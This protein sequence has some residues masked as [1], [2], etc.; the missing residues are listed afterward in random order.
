MHLTDATIDRYGPLQNWQPPCREG[1]T[2]IS[3]PNEAGKTLYLEGLLRL[4]DP[5]VVDVLTSEPRVPEAP[6]GRVTVRTNGDHYTLAEERTL[7]EISAIEPAHLPSIFVVRDEDLALPGEADFYTSLIQKLGNIH[8]TEIESIKDRLRERGRLT[9]ANRNLSS[10]AEFDDAGDVRDRAANLADDIREY[11]EHVK[12][13]G[14]A[15]LE[16]ER[17]RC[18]QALEAALDS[19]ERLAATKRVAE[20]E[21]LSERLEKFREASEE[22]ETLAAFDRETL[23]ALRAHRQEITRAEGELETLVADIEDQRAE[24]QRLEDTLADRNRREMRLSRREEAIERVEQRLAAYRQAADVSG[25]TGRQFALVKQFATAGLIGAGIAGGAGAVSGTVAA[26]VLAGVLAVVGGLAGAAAFAI[27]RKRGRIDERRE[28]TLRAA[29]DAEL[30]CEAIEDVAPAVESFNNDLAVARKERT[31]ADSEL[32]TAREALAE[33]EAEQ[34]DCETE[35]EEGRVEL[36]ETLAAAGVK[37]I[38]DYESA[39][40]RTEDLETDRTS[41]AASLRDRFG[42]PDAESDDDRYTVWRRSL[43]DL[44][45][46]V[47][48]EAHDPT[49]DPETELAAVEEEVNEYE[50]ELEQLERDLAAYQN[51]LDTFERRVSDIEAGPF[52]DEPIRLAARTKAGL[53][54][55]AERLE[56]FVG[57]IDRDAEHSRKAL[58]LFDRIEAAEE[59]K[60]TTLFAPDGRA[61]ATFERIT[62]G[63]YSAI[64]YDADAH[65]LRVERADGREF[66]PDLLSQGTRDQLYFASR[67][68]LAEQLLGSEPGFFLLDDP[69]LAADPERLERGFETLLDLADAGWQIIY[70]T[71][72]PEVFEDM[73]AEY[74]LAHE[75][76]PGLSSL[77]QS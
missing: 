25:R 34:Q 38:T 22:L 9:P 68:S 59:D 43:E 42:D 28:A 33:L 15:D 70:L 52:V 10:A 46:D 49:G 41:A 29:R 30:D 66:P 65:E 2:V 24:L 48:V 64:A 36:E 4:L 62:D 69:F 20:Y 67:I 71:A 17:L 37:S 35:L 31:R 73:V 50:A 56:A 3:G 55:L 32:E 23:D 75:R 14:L 51:R 44:V 58:K 19:R 12:A 21:T 45:A 72:K 6:T 60:L 16:R 26:I 53:E 18:R 11:V 54:A 77:G 39:V 47:D 5:D 1:L 13:E 57:R 7:S 63:R 74:G 40:A 27:D 76:Q 8:T 61:S